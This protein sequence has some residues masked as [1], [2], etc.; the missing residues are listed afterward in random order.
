VIH[1]LPWIVIALVAIVGFDGAIFM[2]FVLLIGLL[3]LNEFYKMFQ[4]FRPLVAAG[5]LGTAAVIVAAKYGDQYQILLMLALTLPLTFLFALAR[6]VR[7]YVTLSMGVTIFGVLWIGV[8]V[9]H[10]VMLRDLPHGAG[11]MIDV[12][13]ATFIGDS[14]AYFGGRLWG[15]RPL[16]PKVSPNKTVEGLIVGFIAGTLAFWAA[17]LYQDWLSGLDALAIG[18][19][20]AAV[21]PI[22]DLFESLLKR[23]AGV[24]DTGRIF[25]EHG[26]V[27]DRLDATLFTVVA[28]Y[29]MSVALL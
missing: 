15:M 2:P 7:R 10:A 9:A 12:L 22:G 25:G 28:G 5:M 14:G 3:G 1:A 4:R 8:A 26:G 19:V 13:L 18:A 29:Y 17:G 27:L 16:A 20:V 6:G 21:A 24:K 11:L 23:D